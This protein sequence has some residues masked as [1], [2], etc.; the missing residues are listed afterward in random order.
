MSDTGFTYPIYQ[1]PAFD[2]M[3][4]ASLRS[5]GGREVRLRVATPAGSDAASASIG[6]SVNCQDVSLSPVVVWAVS[7]AGDDELRFRL[8][9]AA[10][11]IA[12]YAGGFGEAAQQFLDGVVGAV[13]PFVYFGGTSESE[14][15]LRIEHVERIAFGIAEYVYILTVAG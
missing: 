7:K 3:I 8:T 11:T 5:L 13:Y 1:S 10:R 2:R 12:D 4:L 14:R 6:T 9:I 15:L